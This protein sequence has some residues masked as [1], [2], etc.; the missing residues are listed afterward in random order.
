MDI[1][2][3]I[4]IIIMI[5][6]QYK[7][8]YNNEIRVH[9]STQWCFCLNSGDVLYRLYEPEAMPS[10]RNIIQ[11]AIPSIRYAGTFN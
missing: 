11:I 4:D 7:I 9:S 5:K 3:L 2:A 8:G 6:I 10:K 1:N